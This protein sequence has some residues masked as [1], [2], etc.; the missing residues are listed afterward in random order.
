MK[1]RKTVLSD[2][3]SILKNEAKTPVFTVLQHKLVKPV[4]PVRIQC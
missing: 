3:N 2:T 1:Y 4:P